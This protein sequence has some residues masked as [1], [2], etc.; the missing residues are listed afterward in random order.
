[1]EL[2]NHIYK[3]FDHIKEKCLRFRRNKYDNNYSPFDHSGETCFHSTEYRYKLTKKYIHIN[4]RL[5]CH[6]T[7]NDIFFDIRLSV[8]FDN[9][10][11]VIVMKGGWHPSSKIIFN[12]IIEAS[13]FGMVNY[14]KYV[15]LCENQAK[16]IDI[17][18]HI[19][20]GAL[21]QIYLSLFDNNILPELI[22][23][24]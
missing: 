4:Y 8:G 19:N 17:R 5:P 2:D 10:I 13:T 15:K 16:C 6:R 1:M 22:N 3:L 11:S 20:N 23:K 18:E 21:D 12:I 14:T 9:N 24:Y 7:N